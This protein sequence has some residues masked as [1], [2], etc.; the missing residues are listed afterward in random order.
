MK[1]A[2]KLPENYVVQKAAIML[3]NMSYI[4]DGKEG[5]LLKKVRT[6]EEAILYIGIS[7]YHSE[8]GNFKHRKEVSMALLMLF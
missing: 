6:P 1:K 2:A 7:C 4:K 5:K 3:K 8:I